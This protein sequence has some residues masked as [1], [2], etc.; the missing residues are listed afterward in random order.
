MARTPKAP[1]PAPLL[2]V[3]PQCLRFCARLI[4]EDATTTGEAGPDVCREMVAL[5]A[6][7][8]QIADELP[9]D[10]EPEVTP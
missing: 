9:A 3:S 1:Q 5:A 10:T 4:H 6:H 7:M 8:K 2:S